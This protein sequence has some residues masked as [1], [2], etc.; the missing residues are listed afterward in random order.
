MSIYET[1]R[2][3]LTPEGRLPRNYEIPH[4]EAPPNELRWMVGAKDGAFVHHVSPKPTEEVINKTIGFLKAGKPNK[5]PAVFKKL[6]VIDLIDPLLSAIRENAND[7]GSRMVCEYAQF[8]AFESDDEELVKLG[9]ALLGLFDWSEY[10]ETREK[11]ITLGLYEEFT[12]YVVVQAQNW[13]KWNDA[14]FRIAQ[15]VDGWGKIHAVERLKPET[16]EIKDWILCHGCE[17]AV[18]DA[19]LG[20]V[21]ANKGDMIGTLRRDD[22]DAEMFDSICV[23]IDALMDEGPT[24]GISEYEHA[25]EALLRFLRFADRYAVTLR[26]IWHI[27]N[28]ADFLDSAEIAGKDEME[29]LCRGIA[30]KP[31]WKTLILSEIA[32]L[33]SDDFFY[34]N[35]VAHRLNIDVDGFVYD[36]VKKDPIGKSSYVISLYKKPGYAKELTEMYE[37]VLPLDEM[38]TGMGDY[39]FSPTHIRECNCL[40][41]LLQELQEYPLLGERLVRTGLLSPVTRNRNMAC[42]SLEAWSEKL[43]QPVSAFSPSLLETLNSV[44]AVEINKDTKKTMNQL[45][46]GK[47]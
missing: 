36:A 16:D 37:R 43:G 35:N 18:M 39:L 30:D 38:A 44:V 29:G 5:I 9:I 22:L 32:K 46:K 8:L 42:G 27:L 2:E 20:L 19:Y 28:V 33:D 7:I 31:L 12:L 24:A 14:L 21:S 11:I 10:P 26:H 3:A 1:I 4:K 40:D 25:E 6:S 47:K 15:N 41:M 45:I 17:N 13:D 23:V 34:A